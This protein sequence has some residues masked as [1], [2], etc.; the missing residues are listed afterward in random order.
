MNFHTRQIQS[1]AGGIRGLIRHRD[2]AHRSHFFRC[3]RAVLAFG[4]AFDMS[5]PVFCYH[6]IVSLTLSLVAAQAGTAVS[7]RS[8]ALPLAPIVSEC[9]NGYVHHALYAVLVNIG[10]QTFAAIVV[11]DTSRR[12]TCRLDCGYIS[13]IVIASVGIGRAEGGQLY[14]VEI[15]GAR[16]LVVCRRFAVLGTMHTQ[17]YRMLALGKI[18]SGYLSRNI[19]IEKLILRAVRHSRHYRRFVHGSRLAAV[20]G[21]IHDV[22]KIEFASGI[23]FF[24]RRRDYIAVVC[25]NIKLILRIGSHVYGK[26][27]G[28]FLVY[29]G[30]RALER[31]ITHL[32]SAVDI[33]AVHKLPL[34]YS[35]R[36]AAAHERSRFFSLID[37]A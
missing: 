20:Y 1:L 29:I 27:Y 33:F 8:V 5:R 37:G 21:Y 14:P 28:R 11:S 17:L 22:R 19:G 30:F 31:R 26:R 32:S 6:Y 36:R 16:R 4:A 12:F 23:A 34:G 15:D 3:F 10:L 25:T 24:A 9:G 2:Y 13:D 35:R 7:F 18:E